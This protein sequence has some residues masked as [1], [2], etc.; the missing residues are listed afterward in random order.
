M[1]FFEQQEVARRKTSLLVFYYVMA[2]A[3]IVV[4]VYLAVSFAFSLGGDAGSAAWLDWNPVRFFSVLAGTGLIVLSGTVYK[5]A[6]L[7]Q[8]GAAVAGLLGGRA[9]LT[10]TRDVSERRLLN[11][12]EEMALASGTPIPRVYVL[13]E[14]NAINAFA[15]GFNTRDAVI[16]VTRGT[17]E[18]LTRDEL[19]GVI[20]HEFSHI[21][22][23]DMRLNIRL[24]GV[25]FG[26]LLIALIGQGTLRVL[27]RTRTRSRSGKGNGGIVIILLLA[28]LLM[29][30]GYVGVFFAKL[31]KSAVSRQRE[32]L[33][34]AA[35]VQFTRNPSGLASALRKIWKRRGSRLSAV[36]AEE[37]S[38]LFFADGLANAWVSLMATHP[39]I[40]ERIRRI[41]PSLLAVPDAEPEGAVSRR[42]APP[43]R[44]VAAMADVAPDGAGMI[45][46]AG[47]LDADGLALAEA[48]VTGLPESLRAAAQ[49]PVE[50]EAILLALLLSSDAALRSR[51]L[52][53]LREGGDSGPAD[54]VAAVLPAVD[55]LPGPARAPLA[56]LAVAGLRDTTAERY[57]AFRRRLDA[58]IAGDNA[59]SLFEYMLQRMI[60]RRL[61]P[62]FRKTRTVPT[63]FYGARS[64]AE[65]VSTLLSSLA[66]WGADTEQDAVRAFRAGAAVLPSGQP[67]S[68]RPADRCG[69]DAVDLALGE[70]ESASPLMKRLVL[71]ACA[72]CVA[73][74][75]KVTVDEAELIRAV[76]D[77]FD[78]PIPPLA[79]PANPPHRIAAV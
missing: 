59:I 40:E 31:I 46:L 11:V 50:A 25:L 24:M 48:S 61:D 19:Q 60:R 79:I 67:F 17:L 9:I 57:E 63:T 68:L 16:A 77:A 72:A 18:T 41:D 13:D 27:G 75:R 62:V 7:A 35:S 12:V 56:A 70:I 76:A 45:G 44:P 14:E 73:S 66:Y 55:V 36:H 8:G 54:G 64:L 39:P 78:C 2:V 10:N 53:A 74:D 51:Q 38:H 29:A 52:A 33:A 26:I 58:T 4:A 43:A 5:I 21:L 34:D 28:V 49:S 42:S 15:A 32:F 6:Q 3:L 65:P 69:L 30:I 22:N 47:E 71:R 20:G 23:G 1:D 37:A